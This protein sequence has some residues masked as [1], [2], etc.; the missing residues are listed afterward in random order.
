[1]LLLVA[2]NVLAVLDLFQIY[3][4]DATRA[5]LLCTNSNGQVSHSAKRSVLMLYTAGVRNA[6]LQMASFF[7]SGD[8]NVNEHGVLA[9]FH[10]VWSRKHNHL[11]DEIGALF[12]K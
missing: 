7:F 9:A 5:A 8:H 12:R 1:M 2:S 11:A 6:P 4:S 10:I 3:E